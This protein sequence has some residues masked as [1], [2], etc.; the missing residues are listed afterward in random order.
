MSQV[1]P[2]FTRSLA[3]QL[4]G[5][6]LQVCYW[7]ETLVFGD[8]VRRALHPERIIIGCS[9]PRAPLPPALA[10]GLA[11]FGCPVLSMVYE[12]A[13]LT[14]TAINLYLAGS[15]TYANTLS[16]L[17]ESVGARWD[18]MVPALRLDARIG[19][20][21]YLRPGL[22]IAGGNL[23]R[24]LATLSGLCAERGVDATYVDALIT[25][26][27]RRVDWVYR[28][29]QTNV[30]DGAEAPNLAIWGLTYKKNTRSTKNSPALRVIAS[31]GS[32]A[33]IRAWD[34]AIAPGELQIAAEVVTDAYAATQDADCLL[35]MADWDQFAD[36]DARRLRGSMRRPLVIDC[37]GVLERRRSELDGIEYIGMG[38]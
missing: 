23:E 16:D 37:A 24:D 6:D 31:I 35:V 22:G 34:P 13:E 36:V 1:P 12:S 26:N 14:K 10:D 9:E 33:R 3:E 38:R 15:V 8:A 29:L 5:Q 28:H 7:V 18:E 2:G 21:A 27:D 20:A 32:R 30:L 11:R 19:A 4:R 25:Y 17:C